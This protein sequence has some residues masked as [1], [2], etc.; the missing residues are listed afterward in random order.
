DPFCNSAQV[1]ALAPGG[2]T[3]SDEA[4][5]CMTV[6]L[7]SPRVTIQKFTNAPVIVPGQEFLYTIQ[8]TNT[9]NRDIVK[10]YLRE[11]LPVGMSYVSSVYD[12]RVLSFGGNRTQPIW[13]VASLPL[14]ATET[15][16]VRLR[17]ERDRRNLD[18]PVVNV[19][20]IEAWDRFGEHFTDSDFEETPV[21]DIAPAL[22]LNK[23]A[24]TGVLMPGGTVTYLLTLTNGGDEDLFTVSVADTLP[25]GLSVQS[26]GYDALRVTETRELLPG[27]DREVVTWSLNELP[28]GALEQMRLS[29]RAAENATLFDSLVVN[30][31]HARGYNILERLVTDSDSDALPLAGEGAAIGLAKSALVSE[32]VPGGHVTYLFTVRN[33]G[34]ATLHDVRLVDPIPAG[35]SYRQ[36]NFNNTRVA[37]AGAGEGEA[38]WTMAAL[39]VGGF[40]EIRATFLASSS[41]VGNA[42]V[43][44]LANIATVTALD[45]GGRV[46]S[47]EDDERLPIHPR[48]AGV[49]LLKWADA[50]GG[51]ATRGTEI[52]YHVQVVNTGQQDLVPVTV[53][54][55]MP[56]GLRYLE[57][58]Q[59]PDSVVVDD[60]ETRVYWTIAQL[61]P[62][63]SWE[64]LVRARIDKQLVDGEA[65]ENRAHALGIDERGGLVR[66]SDVSRVLAG[67]PNVRIEKTSDRPVARPGE[68]ISYTITYR[69]SGTADAR[70]VVVMD[71]LPAGTAF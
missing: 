64:V 33:A 55:Y 30:T 53:I 57:C 68:R 7:A 50:T 12:P 28:Q 59:S 5:E 36:S 54:D 19:A 58:D 66:A 63:E 45:P 9:G 60:A 29:C 43:D 69:N 62:V 39:P 6:Q 70:N 35:L 23:L 26:T 44:T 49:Q 21:A 22:R 14:G 40:E 48:R 41:L 46:V 1:T 65:I 15:I 8:I 51:L 71:A 20:S 3:V 61:H 42:A 27:L 32:V 4:V 34:S 67:L 10:A 37:F 56:A 24:T 25:A 52:A 47:D 18:D 13:T 11:H 31:A 38:V 16:T 17:A 2:E